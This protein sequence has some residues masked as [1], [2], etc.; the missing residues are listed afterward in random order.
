MCPTQT[1][2]TIQPG[3]MVIDTARDLSMHKK[4]GAILFAIVPA[5]AE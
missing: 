5:D 3:Y 4:H 2:T 1:D